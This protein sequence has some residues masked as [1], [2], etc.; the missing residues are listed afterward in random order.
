ML[1]VSEPMRVDPRITRTHKLLMEAFRS[2]MAEKH[3]EDITVQDITTRATVNRATFYDHFP[4]KYAIVDELIHGGFA[5]VLQGHLA[6]RTT[7][8]RAY[9]RCLFL[10]VTDH[11]TAVH[12][13]CQHSYRLFGTVVEAQVKAQLRDSVRSWLIEHPTP[14]MQFPERLELAATII[15]WAIYGA[16]MEWNKHAQ[17]QAAETFADEVVPFIIAM[18]EGRE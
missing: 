15:S 5:R 1:S 7:T 16:A 17:T 18:M 13:Q 12:A 4:D 8:A 14:Q 6:A 2:L 10:A 3:F 9:V 11:W